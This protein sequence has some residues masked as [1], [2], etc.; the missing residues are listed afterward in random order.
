MGGAWTSVERVWC[1]R[2]CV[3][4]ACVSGG[5][6]YCGGLL[7][8]LCCACVRAAAALFVYLFRRP[9]DRQRPVLRAGHAVVADAD[10]CTRLVADLTNA[11]ASRAD[12][13]PNRR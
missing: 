5:L 8:V 2:V 12:D 6:Y 9:P 4:S 7:G 1:V 13:A 3:C 10:A 11:H